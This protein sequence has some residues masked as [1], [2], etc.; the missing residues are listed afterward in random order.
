[1]KLSKLFLLFVV[2][3]FG[4]S[5][6]VLAS[7]DGEYWS[8]TTFSKK[9]NDKLKLNLLEQFRMKSEMGNFY[10]Y[11]QYAGV[12]Y[13]INSNFDV[14]V[15]YKLVSSKSSQEWSE[16]HRVDIDGTVN[17]NLS[18]LKISDRSR[19]ERNTT[20]NSW[21]YRN[22][23]KLSKTVELFEKDYTP[24]ISNEF[25]LELEPSDGFEENR[26]SVGFSTKFI[27]GTKLTLYYMS[28][29]KKSDGRWNSANILGTTIGFSF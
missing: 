24:F 28:R 12:N 23:L 22:R 10:T 1:M 13:K 25:F 7:D 19:F 2:I 5:S 16:S 3:Y 8:M 18:G 29:A 11:V 9:I 27:W 26:A 14:A 15:W 21:L 17:V 20:A 4:C 6:V